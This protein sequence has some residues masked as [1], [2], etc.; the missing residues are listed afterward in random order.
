MKSFVHVHKIN[1]KHVTKERLPLIEQPLE[2]ANY[3][4]F[5]LHTGVV[6]Q[7]GHDSFSVS[8]AIGIST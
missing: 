2:F 6:D 1:L 5:V 8:S 3:R 7:L 4:E